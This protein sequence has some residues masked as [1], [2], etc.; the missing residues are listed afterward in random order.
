MHSDDAA[1]QVCNSF[2]SFFYSDF[3]NIIFIHLLS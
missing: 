2:L 3:K 1:Y